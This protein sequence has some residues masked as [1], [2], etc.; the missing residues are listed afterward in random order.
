MP[1]ERELARFRDRMRDPHHL[2]EPLHRDRSSELTAEAPSLGG[3][4]RWGNRVFL[5]GTEYGL[6]TPG[7]RRSSC[8]LIDTPMFETPQTFAIRIRWAVPTSPSSAPFAFFESFV[9]TTIN[10]N[11]I[12][13]LRRGVDVTGPVA[14]EQVNVRTQWTLGPDFGAPNAQR[15]PFPT[16]TATQLGI[17]AD[18]GPLLQALGGQQNSAWIEAQVTLLSDIDRHDIRADVGDVGPGYPGAVLSSV[19]ASDTPVNLL[20]ANERRTQFVITNESTTEL[21]I[22]FCPASVLSSTNYTIRIPGQ[23]GGVTF[24]Y[25]SFIQPYRGQV[26]GIWLAEAP[27]GSARITEGFV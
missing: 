3:R 7:G 13:T 1:S 23:S 4:F 11:M 25:E 21:A 19:A 24:A 17:D 18:L 5:C 10:S 12:F 15:W 20:F 14:A 22:G 6:P 8:T 9:N 16:V 27:G 2:R 26:S